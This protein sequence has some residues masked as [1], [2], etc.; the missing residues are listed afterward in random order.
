M[1][2]SRGAFL[3]LI[4]GGVVAMLMATGPAR[5][6]SL[7]LAGLAIVGTFLLLG[8]QRIAE[9]FLTTFDP[10]GPQDNSAQNR[11][12]FWTAASGQL[13][14]YPLGSGGNSFSEGRG[15]RYMRGD[16]TVPTDTRA[17]HNGFLTE[18][19]DW[20]IQGFLLKMLFLGAV[21]RTCFRGRRLAMKAGDGEGSMVY[22][23][24]AGALVAWMVTSIF[25]D[26][27]NEEWGFWV[28]AL[29]YS[30]MRVYTLAPSQQE[31]VQ[32]APVV[33]SQFSPAVTGG[34]AL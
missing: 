20:G 2:N 33:M 22:G 24:L 7:K 14:D 30:Y 10:D 15:W 29:A 17:I 26:Y 18:A 3:G 9:R 21:F 5:K 1:C 4:L 27:L 25:G 32:P 31:E 23:C 16:R 13:R 19:T 28:A 11:I 34:R 6:K 12:V 8:D